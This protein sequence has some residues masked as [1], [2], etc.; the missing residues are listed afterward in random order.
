M[1]R[2]LNL[3]Y[4]DIRIDCCICFNLRLDFSE[5]RHVSIKNMNGWQWPLLPAFLSLSCWYG[6]K[7]TDWLILRVQT[8]VMDMISLYLGI[9]I[10]WSLSIKPS[11]IVSGIQ[12]CLISTAILIYLFRK[13]YNLLS[14]IY[15]SR[16][17]YSVILKYLHGLHERPVLC[18]EW[19]PRFLN[20]NE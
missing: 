1:L 3:F 4:E 12:V 9:Y 19:T 15:T 10:E 6:I 17:I 5:L 16:A 13:L 18:I 8:A 20:K 2:G 7:M 11:W 14:F